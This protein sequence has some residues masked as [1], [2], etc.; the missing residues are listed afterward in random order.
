MFLVLGNAT[1]DEA[2]AAEVWPAPGQTVVV[3]PPV[4]DV[5]GK[6][7]NQALVLARSG[8]AVQLVAPIGRDAEGDWVA[9]RLAEAGLDTSGLVRVDAPTDRSLIFVARDGENAIASTVA[10]ATSL[11]PDAVRAI[12]AGLG[13]GDGLL[14]QGNLTSDA[15]AAA[16]EA[17]RGLGVKTVLNPSPMQPG[18]AD[19]LPLVD[20]LVL[21]ESEGVQLGGSGEPETIAAELAARSGGLVVLT[22]GGRGAI[23]HGPDVR[24][25]V[26]ARAVL[27]V[28]TTG[29]GDT[30]AGV[31]VAAL[32]E[33]R[34]PV[35]AAVAAASAAAS[36]T[37]Q[38]KGTL[39]AFPS[40][41][42]IEA[43]FAAA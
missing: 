4:R 16:L 23:V 41:A 36:L 24:T 38:R 15:T 8:A 12:L 43:I 20:L 3:G 17:A 11:D 22:L 10:A 28:D 34:L 9:A 42:E 2:M 35:P 7:A 29:A 37:V 30:F 39:A 18:F 27:V 26:P 19:I 13:A 21:N 40:R 1:I 25:A 14:L 31:L 6:G 33:R 5:G 32:W